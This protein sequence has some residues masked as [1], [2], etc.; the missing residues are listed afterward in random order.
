MSLANHW[1]HSIEDYVRLEFL[2][3]RI[4]AMAGGTPEHGAR[5]AAIIA[6]LSAQLRGSQATARARVGILGYRNGSDELRRNRIPCCDP[7]AAMP[8]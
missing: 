5:A 7:V 8:R 4:L 2:G 3:G 1:K 6:T